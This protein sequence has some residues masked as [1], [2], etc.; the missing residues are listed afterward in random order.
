MSVYACLQV[1]SKAYM[2]VSLCLAS[3]L[4]GHNTHGIT[5]I[6]LPCND[7]HISSTNDMLLLTRARLPPWLHDYSIAARSTNY[8]CGIQGRCYCERQSLA[9]ISVLVFFLHPALATHT[10]PC[11]MRSPLPYVSCDLR[12]TSCCVLTWWSN[13][14]AGIALD[15]CCPMLPSAVCACVCTFSLSSLLNSAILLRE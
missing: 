3:V 6:H 10:H 14:R 15:N 1:S 13:D 4:I 11:L 7:N 9:C 2:I 8:P 12:A 5:P